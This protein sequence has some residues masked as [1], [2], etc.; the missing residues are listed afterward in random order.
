[1]YWLENLGTIEKIAGLVPHLDSSSKNAL[2]SVESGEVALCW[3][4][5][6]EEVDDAVELFI[7]TIEWS[8]SHFLLLGAVKSIQVG[9]VSPFEMLA[10]ST[11]SSAVCKWVDL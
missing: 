1:M 11:D 10:W 5:K 4:D 3:W 8:I 6:V 9:T 7:A 2:S